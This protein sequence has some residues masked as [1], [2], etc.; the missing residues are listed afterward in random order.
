MEKKKFYLP[1]VFILLLLFLPQLQAQQEEIIRLELS[2]GSILLGTILS[3]DSTH[4]NFLTNSNLQIK[5]NKNIILKRKILKVNRI[6]GNLWRRDPNKTRLFF[7]PT[8]R[9]LKAG[10]GYF[11]VY[12]IFFP[13]VAVGITD[14]LAISGGFSLLPGAESQLLYLAPKIT[15][16]QLEK[17]DV[18]AGILYLKIPEETDAAGIFYGVG[19]Y[20][21]ENASITVGLGFAFGAGEIAD[22]PVFTIGAELRSSNTVAFI[23]ENWLIPDSEVQVIS[24]GLRFFGENLA[25][26]FGLIGF[27]GADLE[28]FPFVPWIGFTYNF[29]TE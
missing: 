25:A 28:G 1:T 2:G 11:S 7:A 18:S 9:A 14:F 4:I 15:P 8:G 21:N 23:T 12:E 26:D 29:G 17:I 6:E 5:I 20:G 3:E 19:T 13:F 27:P 22:K 24:G 10:Q 16:V